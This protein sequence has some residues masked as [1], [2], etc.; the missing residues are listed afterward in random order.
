EIWHS[1]VIRFRPA[2]EKR[3]TIV[4]LQMEYRTPVGGFADIVAR[5]FQGAARDEVKMALRP[6]KQLMETGEVATTRGQPTGRT[7]PSMVRALE[8]ATGT[9]ESP[10][11]GNPGSNRW[12]Q[13]QPQQLQE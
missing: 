13:N 6:F 1:G 8:R 4:Q 7:H 12:P 9:S 10:A 2:H 3:G 5:L 11:A